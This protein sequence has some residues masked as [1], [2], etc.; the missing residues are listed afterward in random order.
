M[1]GQPQGSSR[2]ASTEEE[3]E[4]QTRAYTTDVDGCQVTGALGPLY[5]APVTIAGEV[6]EALVDPGSSAS[7]RRF[8]ELDQKERRSSR[9]GSEEL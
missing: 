5:Y 7:I 1:S 8:R 4:R 2:D 9:C 6:V 3:F